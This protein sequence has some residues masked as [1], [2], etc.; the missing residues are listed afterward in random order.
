MVQRM[1][2]TRSS[3]PESSWP[4][5]S[6]SWSFCEGLIKAFEEAWRRGQTPDISDYLRAEGPE[7]RALL[8][9]L[10][11]VDLEFRLKAGELTRV[12]VYLR[13]YPELGDDRSAILG[14]IAA[15]C[16]L[17]RIHQSG[18]GTE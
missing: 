8:L 1:R 6:P 15:E 17:R 7:R 14:L 9:E 2:R 10:I 5:T 11:H 16:E 18:V 4:W 12:E 13:D 3:N